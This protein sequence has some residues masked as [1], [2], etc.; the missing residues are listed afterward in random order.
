MFGEHSLQDSRSAGTG[1][2]LIFFDRPAGRTVFS[3]VMR[4]IAHKVIEIGE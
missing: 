3:Y 2:E 4:E 1:I